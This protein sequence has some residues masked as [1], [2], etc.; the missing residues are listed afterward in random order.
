MAGQVVDT[1]AAE[2]FMQQVL[3]K[4]TAEELQDI[5]DRAVRKAA[6]FRSILGNPAEEAPPVEGVRR[7]LG[8]MFGVRKKADFAVAAMGDDPARVVQDLFA[9][10]RPL[11]D[12]IDGFVAAMSDSPYA[13]DI[14]GELLHFTDPERYWLWTRWMW[15]PRTET[16]ALRL[17][18]MDEFDL[19]APSVGET[20]VRVGQAVAFVTETGRAVG[21]TGQPPFGIDVFLSCVYGIYMYTVL[22]MRMTQEFNAVVPALPELAGRL[23]GIYRLEE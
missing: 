11:V 15:D 1:G 23:L 4:V 3:G 8:T 21:F 19:A 2:E 14:A 5:A 6:L 13:T 7:A 18:T 22:R 10:D 9:L 12:R 17:V 16:G 20:Y